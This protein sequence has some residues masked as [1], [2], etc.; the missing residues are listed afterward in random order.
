V[1]LELTFPRES[2]HARA[3]VFLDIKCPE[4]GKRGSTVPCSVTQPAMV[5]AQWIP[6][7]TLFPGTH[8]LEPR[9]TLPPVTGGISPPPS[10]DCS[11]V[12]FTYLYWT[13]HDFT[14]QDPRSWDNPAATAS[15]N[16]SLTS[17]VTGVC[18]RCQWGQG[19]GVAEYSNNTMIPV[20]AP[21]VPDPLHSDSTF[22]LRFNTVAKTVSIEQRWVCGG[23]AGTYS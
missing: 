8:H 21:E 5:K 17:R 19:V 6:R 16:I 4:T 1:A 2:Y 23:T 14:Y 7:G 20:C 18:V 9:P 3:D 22:L 12:S 11:D 10:R 13:I 15:L